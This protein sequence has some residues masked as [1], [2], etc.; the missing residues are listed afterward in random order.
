MRSHFLR[1]VQKL[2]PVDNPF[3]L[4]GSSTVGTATSG[5]TISATIPAGRMAGDFILIVHAARSTT[6]LNM[7]L[8]DPSY[9]TV[10]DLY[11]DDNG[12]TNLGVH[13]KISD[14][15][16][17]TVALPGG[18]EFTLATCSVQVWR[19][20]DLS[21]PLDVA[22]TT[23]TGINSGIAVSP[24]IITGTADA[25]VLGT[26]SVMTG[27]RTTIVTPPPGF[28]DLS[29]GTTASGSIIPRAAVASKLALVTGSTPG[30]SWSISGGDSILYSWCACT[31]ALRPA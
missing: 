20:V 30:G 25:L 5:A 15:T 11:A 9:T 23:A 1:A 2:P 18:A 7:S 19:G 6:D 3:T 29:A 13:W 14:G 12:D 16:E 17:T 24:A 4:V 31:I 26:A 10:A 21:S 27:T 28:S 8:S 22:P